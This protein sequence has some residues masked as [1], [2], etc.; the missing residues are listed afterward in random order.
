[1]TGVCFGVGFYNVA[2]PDLK[3]T[4][5]VSH[6]LKYGII[7]IHH[8]IRLKPQLCTAFLYAPLHFV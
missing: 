2:H 4:T 8:H 5:L 6:T 1:M 7:V 3:L